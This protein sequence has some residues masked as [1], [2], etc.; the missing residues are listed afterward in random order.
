M[1]DFTVNITGFEPV[2]FTAPTMSKA[3]YAAWRQF[4]EAYPGC[5]FKDFMERASI[6]RDPSVCGP[7]DDGATSQ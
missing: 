1:P 3:R 4:A 2:T 6:R 7:S 5:S